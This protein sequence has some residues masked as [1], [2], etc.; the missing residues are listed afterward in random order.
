MNYNINIDK[1][2]NMLTLTITLS[3][4]RNV[5]TPKERIGYRKMKKLLD[6]NLDLPAGFVLGECK[7]SHMSV[8]NSPDTPESATWKFDLVP[9][10]KKPYLNL[11]QQERKKRS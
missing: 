4:R 2:N 3:V 1:Q 8:S 11:K 6:E 7:N 5:A 10:V 9:T